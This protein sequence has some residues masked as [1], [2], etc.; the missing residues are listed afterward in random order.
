MIPLQNL[1]DDIADVPLELG[2]PMPL[3]NGSPV[4]AAYDRHLTATEWLNHALATLGW[5]CSEALRLSART[6]AFA[7]IPLRKEIQSVIPNVTYDNVLD[8]DQ[9]LTQ[10]AQR[11]ASVGRG[12]SD[13]LAAL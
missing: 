9:R 7:L 12:E 2:E 11:F 13:E 6:P 3:V 10:I 1:F 5:V 8:Y 4:F